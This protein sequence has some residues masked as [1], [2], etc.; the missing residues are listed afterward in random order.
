MNRLNP[1]KEDRVRI[2]R[3]SRDARKDYWLPRDEARRRYDNGLLMYD[4]TN[5]CYCHRYMEGS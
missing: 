3:D 4:V 5:R 1:P 2:I